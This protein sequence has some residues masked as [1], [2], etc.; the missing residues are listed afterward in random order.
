MQYKT[1]R[2]NENLESEKQSGLV[3][4]KHMEQDKQEVSENDNTAKLALKNNMIDQY[5]S[6]KDFRKQKVIEQQELDKQYMELKIR[7]AHEFRQRENYQKN[8]AANTLS[9]AL[10]Q[11]RAKEQIKRKDTSDRY[12]GRPISARQIIKDMNV[13]SRNDG[14]CTYKSTQSNGSTWNQYSN[15]REKIEFDHIFRQ[16]LRPNLYCRKNI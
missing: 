7:E 8:E 4:V 5:L 14:Q 3:F 9:K 10:D 6:S 15:R 1:R 12:I 13:G 11:M 16:N 2:F